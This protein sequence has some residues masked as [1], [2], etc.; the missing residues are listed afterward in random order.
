[1]IVNSCSQWFTHLHHI[2][3]ISIRFRPHKSR[4]T[5]YAF[6]TFVMATTREPPRPQ[7]RHAGDG[8]GLVISCVDEERYK[9]F[10]EIHY[11]NSLSLPKKDSLLSP[12]P[13]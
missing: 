4:Q 13:I 7:C 1:M 12:I 9:L 10:E 3:P 5:H 8:A 2:P 11:D 6:V